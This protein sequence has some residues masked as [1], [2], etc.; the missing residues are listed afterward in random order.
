MKTALQ[1][2]SPENSDDNISLD[3]EKKYTHLALT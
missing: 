3:K 1:K 2:P